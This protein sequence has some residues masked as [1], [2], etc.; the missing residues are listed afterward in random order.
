VSEDWFEARKMPVQ[1]A[2]VATEHVPYPH[3]WAIPKA[4]DAVVFALL[5]HGL[6]VKS[7]SRPAAVVAGVYE[8]LEANQSARSYQK[9]RM[10]SFEVALKR[11]QETLPRGTIFVSAR[12]PLARLGAQLLEAVSEDSLATW[13]YFDSAIPAIEP[14]PDGRFP[15]FPVLRVEEEPTLTWKRVLSAEIAGKRVRILK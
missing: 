9:H 11:R 1:T 6:E 14:G 8:I 2:F 4:S 12:Q 15:E 10:R 7:L 5:D 3:G 13:N